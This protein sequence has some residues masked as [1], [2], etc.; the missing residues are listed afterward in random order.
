[1]CLLRLLT[2]EKDLGHRCERQRTEERERAAV[3]VEEW[4]VDRKE[5]PLRALLVICF[6]LYYG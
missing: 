5:E 4:S 3:S 6:G 1:M 2:L